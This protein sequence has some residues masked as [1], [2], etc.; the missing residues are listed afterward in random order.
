MAAGAMALFGEKYGDEVR[1]LR[2]GDFS[3]ELCGGVHVERTG[4]IGAFLLLGE[5][6]V[7]SG[8]RRVEAVTGFGA[9]DLVAQTR[10]GLQDVSAALKCA[11][12]EATG[13][14][15]QLQQR[16]R[17]AE[18]QLAA[19]ADRQAAAAGADLA[20]QAADVAG[21][22]VLAARI[23]GAD[24]PRL[25]S[26]LDQLKGQLGSAAIVLSAVNEGKVSLVAGVTK[27][28]TARV[29][30]GD[31]VNHVAGQ[32]GGKGGGRPDMAQAGGSQPEHLDAALASVAGW[33]AERVDG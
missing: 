27:D 7:A 26:T 21:M 24:V 33:I 2:F 29:R 23:D 22:K 19:A 16:L 30:A 17:E 11:P 9:L 32:V 6:G 14:L 13:K 5:G 1:V 28:Q 18:K 8:V 3:T 20:S 12:E 4:D 10:R 25:R 15:E 31:L